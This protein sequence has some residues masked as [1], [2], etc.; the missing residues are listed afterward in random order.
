LKTARRLY[1]RALSA[2]REANDRWGAA[3]SLTDLGYIDCEEGNHAAAQAA[4]CESLELFAGLGHRR[5]IA[6]TLEASACLALAQGCAERALRLAGAAAYLRRQI[7][8]RLTRAE[9]I[10]L[11]NSLLPAWNS[12]ADQEAKQAWEEGAAL[13][14][15]Q[16]IQYS[17][18]ESR[19]AN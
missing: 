18:Q 11:D 9:Q 8:A 13:T 15:E 10:K 1:Q 17:L 16:A 12:L 2:F 14:L 5:G 7:G 4:Y 3:R 6:R 19:A